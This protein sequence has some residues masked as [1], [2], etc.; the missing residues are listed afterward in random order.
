MSN[1]ILQTNN[2]D[3]SEI[4]PEIERV[5]G[6]YDHR[7][8]RSDYELEQMSQDFYG[9]STRSVFNALSRD[10]PFSSAAIFVNDIEQ[11]SSLNFN[12]FGRDI[13]QTELE[14]PRIFSVKSDEFDG[15]DKR[16]V[17][18]GFSFESMQ[19]EIADTSVF[20]GLRKQGLMHVI[21][22]NFV[23]VLQRAQ[24]EHFICDSSNTTAWVKMGF[25]AKG[26]KTA[27]KALHE[28]SR[29]FVSAKKLEVA[30]NSPEL[31]LAFANS[32]ANVGTDGLRSL[33]KFDQMA[34]GELR[35]GG[36]VEE[37]PLYAW[38]LDEMS[39]YLDFD[40]RNEEIVRELSKK[41]QAKLPELYA[42]YNEP[43]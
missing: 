16:L 33:L 14:D 13:T 20:E 43:V 42:E 22:R 3:L 40:L 12:V 34:K 36:R 5:S 30:D 18:S 32:I 6:F 31:L 4:W 1:L 35:K 37:K 41:A 2:S 11:V 21:L 19:A 28:H 15:H 24:V 7:V 8:N 9:Q 23:D 26:E 29:H 27:Q 25:D 17:N 39:L 10:I 38:I